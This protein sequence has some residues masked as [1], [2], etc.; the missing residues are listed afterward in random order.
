MAGVVV[1]GLVACSGEQPA[2]DPSGQTGPPPPAEAN[3]KTAPP[4]ADSAQAAAD[5]LKDNLTDGSHAELEYDGDMFADAGLTIDSMWALMAAGDTEAAQKAADW[6]ALRDTA[7][8]YAGDGEQAAYPS[9]MGKLALAY[10]TPG[11][12]VSPEY[13]PAD[14]AASIAGRISPEGRFRDI[15]EW[16]D[17]STPAGQAFDII[18]LVQ[19][20]QL[21]GL[22]ADPVAGLLAVGCED[23]SY[24]SMFDTDPPC[25]GD[26]DTTAIVAQAMLAAGQG[27]VAERAFDYLLTAQTESGRWQSFGVDSV[28]STALAVGA[29]SLWDTPEAKDAAA[30]GMEELAAWQLPKT[31]AFPA[32]AGGEGDLRATAQGILGLKGVS[33]L[34]LLDI[35]PQ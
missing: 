1:L 27:E 13:K 19:L 5:W 30:L 34:D 3:T 10:L 6:L 11:V 26:V 12:T 22:T 35:H 15:S 31:A 14:L 7:I 23:G 17:N 33:Y 24:P 29:L 32:V 18:L 28:N 21:D 4:T 9:A 16:G 25:V 8:D 20:G 2:S